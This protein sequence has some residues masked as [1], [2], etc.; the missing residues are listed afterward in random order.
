MKIIPV[1]ENNL[2]LYLHLT[3]CYEAEF[4]GLTHK[5]PD[6]DGLFELDTQL[7]EKVM[8][9]LLFINESPAG[10]AAI[11]IKEE[12]SYEVSEFYVVPS[13]RRHSSGMTFAH[14]LWSMFPGE[15]EI[16]QIEGAAYATEFWRKTITAY[17][18][19]PYQEERYN[20]PYWGMVTRQR[21]KI[22]ALPALTEAEVE[23]T[24]ASD[25]NIKLHD[26]Q[27]LYLLIKTTGGK[28]WRLKYRDKGIER[29]V[30]LG[31]Y[32]EMPLSEARIHCALYHRDIAQ[33]IDPSLR[34]KE[35]KNS[36]PI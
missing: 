34:R 5:K 24:L 33:N 19:T 17:D 7:G 4:S 9:L 27:G 2:T 6:A 18:H 32:P 28:L 8:G 12:N 15:W 31:K 20:D 16:K 10:L 11:T 23:N 21:F 25:T 1:A 29:S 36:N 13:F 3:Q 22:E 35:K 30:T 26:R 14:R